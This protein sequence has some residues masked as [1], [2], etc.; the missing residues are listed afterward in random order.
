MIDLISTLI[1]AG[2]GKLRDGKREISGSCPMHVERTGKPDR[3]PSWSIN[4]FSLLH[5]C[6]ACHYSGT[7]SQLLTDIL[8]SAP[9]DLEAEIKQQDFIR[10]MA[11]VRDDP[12]TAL[13]PVVPILTE[14]MLQHVLKPVPDRV[15]D[16]RNLQRSAIDA[17][18]VRYDS[19]TKQ[20][21][22]P[23]RSS[24]GELL[25]AQY[26][27]SG[28]VLTLPEGIAKST[29]LYGYSQM[30]CFD[31]VALVESPLDCSRMYGCGIPCV[32]SLGA[33]VS[34]DQ[35]RL[36]A[37][38]FSVVY[39]ALDDDKTGREGTEFAAAQLRKMGCAT[40]PWNYAGMTDE[41]GRKAKDVGDAADDDM[42]MQ[43]WHRT[44]RWGL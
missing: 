40:V 39:L 13:E 4:K 34:I 42:L 21:V 1:Q 8:G 44:Q 37:R 7:L 14:F 23:V 35:C 28:S 15:L 29:T 22:M 33:W 16:L 19:D 18:G 43:S 41:E 27:N 2:I 32:S 11:G 36:L 20:V 9:E 25:G 30:E 26:R 6:Q 38:A 3:H 5:Y 31:T 12:T 10:R 24:T 17:Y